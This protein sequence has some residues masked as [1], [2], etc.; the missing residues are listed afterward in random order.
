MRDWAP[1]V[2]FGDT[3]AVAANSVFW[4]ILYPV[5]EFA[6]AGAEFVREDSEERFLYL[7]RIRGS[8]T[9]SFGGEVQDEVA[10]QLMPMGLDYETP[11]VL[12]PY[13]TPWSFYD[14]EW[15][16]MRFWDRRLYQGNAASYGGAPQTL[17]HPYWTQVDVNP[18]TLLGSKD[19]LW[20]CLVIRNYSASTT[21]RLIHTLRAFYK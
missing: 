7:E 5:P 16:N 13:T 12:E 14:S 21:F 19:N 2:G 20:P 18:R 15:A 4:V 3:I 11:A 9:G 17:D 1:M 6:T 10:W 8:I